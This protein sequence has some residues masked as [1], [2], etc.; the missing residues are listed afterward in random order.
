[1]I[2]CWFLPLNVESFFDS[3]LKSSGNVIQD[4]KTLTSAKSASE[5]AWV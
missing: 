2:K 4:L 5:F 3:K 1:M